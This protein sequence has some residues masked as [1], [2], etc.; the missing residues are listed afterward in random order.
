ML[1]KFDLGFAIVI[2][3]ATTAHPA[4]LCKVELICGARP[5]IFSCRSSDEKRN[6]FHAQPAERSWAKKWRD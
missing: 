1:D 3:K 4:F 2:S 5:A 6:H